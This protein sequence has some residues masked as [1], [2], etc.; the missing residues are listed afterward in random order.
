M[1]VLRDANRPYGLRVARC[2]MDGGTLLPVAAILR[3][4]DGQQFIGLRGLRL[5]L[6]RV[7]LGFGYFVFA[8]FADI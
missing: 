6:V 7:L 1:F 8:M 2:H 3:Q 4:Y 5:V